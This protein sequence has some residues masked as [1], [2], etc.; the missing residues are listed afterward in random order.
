M[1][2]HQQTFESK[3]TGCRAV[4]R[5][6]SQTYQTYHYHLLV[7]AFVAS[8][9]GLYY[10]ISAIY[11]EYANRHSKY[12]HQHDMYFA[13]SIASTPNNSEPLGSAKSNYTRSVFLPYI[14]KFRTKDIPLVWVTVHTRTK[15]VRIDMPVDTGST[16]LL[17]G[18]PLLP[19]I[20]PGAGTRGRQYLS[21]S[22]IVYVGRYLDLDL[23]F[24]G[25]NGVSAETRVPVL[26]VDKSWMCPWYDPSKHGFECPLGPEGQKPVERN[27]SKITY[28]GVGFGR[29]KNAVGQ[30]TATSWGNPFLNVRSINGTLLGPRDMKAGYVVST[31]GIQLGLTK[32]NTRGYQF[33]RLERGVTHASDERDWAMPRMQFLVN[34]RKSI[35][36]SALIDTGIP[37]MYIRSEDNMPLPEVIIKN[38]KEGPGHTPTVHRVKNGTKITI[39]FG[40]CEQGELPEAAASY[41]FEVGESSPMAPSY[42]V[43]GRQE[44]P[45]YVNTGRNFLKG[46]S[47]AFDAIDGRL[48]FR[49]VQTYQSML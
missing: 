34:G 3:D 45:P 22:H 13:S 28:M 36:G 48:G 2:V 40:A 49:P 26:I 8:L 31:Q 20:D 47:I 16:G 17:I 32:E 27:V 42:V 39:D 5:V 30:R 23:T 38:P 12:H 19:G 11:R 41:S 33:M 15:D 9:Y 35:P 29:N 25:A 44:P 6:H 10:Q 46:Y 14:H 43:P 37:Q 1:A 21:S 7:V 18:A 4:T 24:H